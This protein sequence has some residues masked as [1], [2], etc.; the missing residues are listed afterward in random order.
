MNTPEIIN[1]IYNCV[2]VLK[3]KLYDTLNFLL[4]FLYIFKMYKSKNEKLQSLHEHNTYVIQRKTQIQ[5]TSE[6]GNE[7]DINMSPEKKKIII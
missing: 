4:N 7:L 1:S 2:D 3:I 6:K 5:V